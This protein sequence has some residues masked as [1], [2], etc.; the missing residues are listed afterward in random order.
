VEPLL[1][2]CHRVPHPPNKGDKI[3][4][5]H[6]LRALAREH[7]VFLGAFVD[8]PADR[9]HLSMLSQWCAET[10]IVTLHR[11]LARLGSLRGLV[12]GQPLTL[13]YYWNAELAEW[14]RQVVAG[15]AIRK[16]LVF[17]SGMGQYLDLV[18]EVD[19][20]IDFV[21]LDSLKWAEYAQRH[22]WPMSAIYRREAERLLI[23]ERR[24]AAG[25]AAACFVSSE[26]AELFKHA[27]PE[28][29]SK[30]MAILNGVDSDY[31]SPSLACPC[32]YPP[33]VRAIVFTGVMD[34]WP[35]VDAVS[36]FSQEV[37]PLLRAQAPD[38]QFYIVGMNPV[39]A[40][41][42]LAQGGA[43]VVTGRVDDVRPYLQHA[44]LAVAPLR[45]ARGVQNK[46]LEAMSIGLP[47]V[48]SNPAVTGLLVQ[49]GVELHVAD[50][51][52]TYARCC[53]QVLNGDGAITMGSAARARV[54]ASYSWDANLAPLRRM[55]AALTPSVAL[56]QPAAATRAALEA[57][58]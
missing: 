45:V 27:A 10:K 13:P 3:R 31:F 55:L 9:P 41:R 18:P 50:D 25:A 47:V 14:V 4:S 36:W 34:Y 44:A 32:P 35:N 40:V 43:V 57:Q 56:N 16:A 37:L 19:A 33:G 54:L 52:E 39:G 23:Y 5:H 11:R 17:S 2:L 29:A 46:V 28:C 48:A 42:D 6:M 30:T 12:R 15:H 20:V 38:V 24:I 58:P 53:A 49:R 22:A 8:D 7:R 1:F 21:D 51:P 26:E